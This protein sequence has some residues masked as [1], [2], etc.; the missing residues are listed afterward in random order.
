MAGLSAEQA[1]LVLGGE[2]AIWSET[3]DPA[4][5]DSV[6]WPR[7]CAA[8]EVLWSGAT[9]A[10]GQNRSQI[11]AQPR[12]NEMRERMVARGVLAQPLQPAQCSQGMNGSA[13]Q[14]L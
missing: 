11:D 4:N 2:V 10:G 1:K 6:V 8:G 13:C 12:L 14:A 7:A 3:I 5:L 9:T